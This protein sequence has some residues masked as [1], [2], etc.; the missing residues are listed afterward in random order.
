MA[1]MK[2]IIFLS[3]FLLLSFQI[4]ANSPMLITSPS[5]CLDDT[6]C[7]SDEYC[8]PINNS[9]TPRAG[10]RE[11]CQF[12]FQSTC[13]KGLYCDFGDI[14]ER[15]VPTG[16]KCSSDAACG[17]MGVCD[18]IQSDNFGK[19]VSAGSLRSFYGR[20]CESLHD[21]ATLVK[22]APRPPVRSPVECVT[23][24][25]RDPTNLKKTN[26]E[27][28]NRKNDLC[29]GRRGLVCKYSKNA[30]R[31]VCQQKV[32]TEPVF[33]RYCTIGSPFSMC[34]P[35]F[36]FPNVCISNS[37]D[38]TGF[39]ECQTK[40]EIVRRGQLCG[41]DGT[42]NGICEPG[43][44]CEFNSEVRSERNNAYFSCVQIVGE[45]EACP[46]SSTTK[47]GPGLFCDFGVCRKGSLVT[48]FIRYN[49]E[50]IRCAHRDCAP[51]LEC[52][53]SSR[54]CQKPIEVVKKGGECFDATQVRRVSYLFQLQ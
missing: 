28:C 13:K 40:P 11:T 49:G 43:L 21:C 34:F 38:G 1:S 53:F 52:E 25:C 41:S 48:N 10:L 24:V 30:G 19:C 50:G 18:G 51:G 5:V 39:L 42:T 32:T 20:S 27:P 31:S 47:C 35:Q 37:F 14:C 3:C 33:R 9:C 45:G 54:T 2:M 8:E 12:F 44:S 6:E 36:G 46:N 7:A 29:D 26:G 23:G 16:D 17:P 15:I 4:S 22:D